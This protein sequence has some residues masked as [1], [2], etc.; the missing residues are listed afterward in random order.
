MAASVRLDGDTMAKETQ[1]KVISHE[2]FMKGMATK[3]G[4]KSIALL[5][6]H[7]H[8]EIIHWSST[9]VYSL[10]DAMSWALPGGRVVEYFGAESSG[11]TTAMMAAMIENARN[12]GLNFCADAEG[13]FDRDRYAQM[14]GDPDKVTLFYPSTLENFYDW[15]KDLIA[16]AK[17]QEVPTTSVILIAVDTLPMLIPAEV[18]KS[19]DEDRTVGA[20]ARVNSQHLPTIDKALGQNTC[21]LLL[22]Q[23]RD[24]IGAMAWTQEGNIDTP[25]G[26]IVKHIAS[27]RVLFNKQGQI[28][29]GKSADAREIIGMKTGAKVV[30]SKVGP[31][32]RKVDY[33]I[34]FDERGVDN[35]DAC[36]QAFVKRK[37]IPAAVKGVYKIGETTFNRNTW[38]Q[39]VKTHP[40]WVAKALEAT[41]ELYHE[42]IDVSRYKDD[43]ANGSDGEAAE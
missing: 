28:D 1:P 13:T 6:N 32:L 35:A 2:A 15:A 39:F 33:R 19:T 3:Y 26:R 27:L 34:M 18:L 8:A 30:K 38:P 17:T 4:A 42:T 11:K 23:V 7:N 40:K 25:G 14:G 36:L 43:Q 21:L 24:K 29:N 20:A 22:N 5:S 37:L 9:G 31:P 12:G 10:D 16:W 41:F